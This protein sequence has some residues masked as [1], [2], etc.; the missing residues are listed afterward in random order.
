VPSCAITQLNVSD[1]AV[2]VVGYPSTEHL[3]QTTPHHPA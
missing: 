1:G 3:D 2:T